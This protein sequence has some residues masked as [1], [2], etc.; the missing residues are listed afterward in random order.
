LV[1]VL[2][3]CF[4]L[5]SSVTHSSQED[6]RSDRIE[7][8]RLPVF[9]NPNPVDLAVRIDRLIAR[10]AASRDVA[11]V[12]EL[13]RLGGA[14]FPLLIPR[15]AQYPLEVRLRIA[16]ALIPVMK[17]MGWR[18]ASELK[19]SSDALR[20]LETAW[21]E[22]AADFHPS[23]VTRWVERLAQRPNP[24]LYASVIEFD[25]FALPALMTALT[26]V[27]SAIDAQASHRLTLVASR[28]TGNSWVVS[29]SESTTGTR[30]IVERWQRWWQLHASEYTVLTGP[31]R[32]AASLGETR[33]GHWLMLA[34]RFSFGTA[35]NETAIGTTLWPASTRT[36][37]LFFMT[38]LGGWVV[39]LIP[40]VFAAK[41][42][43]R[44][45]LA[46]VLG[47]GLFAI[48]T[49]SV[50]ALLSGA[51]PHDWSL[52]SA[53]V[54]AFVAAAAT[55]IGH[56]LSPIHLPVSL[57]SGPV[58]IE[59]RSHSPILRLLRQWQF[60]GHN[61]PFSLILVFVTE[62]AFGIDGLSRLTVI[63][64]RQRDLN[65]L[66][67]ITTATATCLLLVEFAVQ[68]RRRV[69][70]DVVVQTEAV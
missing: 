49:L 8:L 34:T 9:F 28:I 37:G 68:L 67:A 36:L 17:R 65:T 48:P 2:G 42:T 54:T 69:T 14:A 58:F 70:Q 27:D 47:Q 63:A 12:I 31:A 35:P 66:M 46:F 25:S 38:T 52:A 15:L 24:E 43:R 40:S 50:V 29:N 60:A 5:L 4:G 10:Q 59:R 30:I 11:A 32:W 26:N 62:S 23:I 53:M 1:F 55:D 33:F 22:R 7:Q 16:E 44:A 20:F 6:V 21:E 64:F 45:A 39:S 13:Q 56:R 41:R 18:G 57:P 61:W 19:S 3:L 51:L